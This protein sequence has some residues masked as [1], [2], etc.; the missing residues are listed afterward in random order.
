MAPSQVSGVVG[1]I[2]V[3]LDPVARGIASAPYED[4]QLNEEDTRAVAASKA[5]L[6]DNKPIPP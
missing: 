3:M 2:E 4:E 1:L 5:R 6:K